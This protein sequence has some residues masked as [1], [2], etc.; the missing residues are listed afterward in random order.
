MSVYVLC[1]CGG[2]C[3]AMYFSF[4]R[5]KTNK[6][7]DCGDD[8]TEHDDDDYDADNWQPFS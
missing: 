8:D 6:T 2:V 1:C 7:Y 3:D 5:H 4:L